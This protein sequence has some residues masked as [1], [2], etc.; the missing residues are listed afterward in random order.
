[1]GKD[2]QEEAGLLPV[3]DGEAYATALRHKQ[4]QRALS[5]LKPVGITLSV[6]L[7]IITVIWLA[8]LLS[9]P[10]YDASVDL[11]YSPARDLVTYK[12]VRFHNDYNEKTIYQQEPSPEVD[13]AWDDLY[14]HLVVSR[15]NAGQAAKLG[16]STLRIATEPDNFVMGLDVFHQLHC[17]N[18]IR[19]VLPNNLPYY[20]EH[21]DTAH[22]VVLETHHAAHCVEMLRQLLIC[23]ADISPVTWKWDPLLNRSA[24]LIYNEHQCRDFDKVREWAFEHR[25]GNG[26]QGKDDVDPG[27]SQESGEPVALVQISSVPM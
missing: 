13:E 25:L 6:I 23:N 14:R 1:M 7:N 22:G 16:E 26:W 2:S 12:V 9:R 3:D 18:G 5:K 4:G 8:R 11:L 15:I 17:L 24:P 21:N 10:V 19:K 27:N 20:L